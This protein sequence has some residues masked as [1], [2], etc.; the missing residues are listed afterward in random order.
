[1]VDGSG[2]EPW[3]AP[4]LVISVGALL[5]PWLKDRMAGGRVV[6]A[7][8]IDGPAEDEID[9]DFDPIEPIP[10]EFVSPV[11]HLRVEPDPEL[12]KSA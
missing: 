7:V 6:A 5:W 1:M 2:V 3:A 11:G 9:S 12:V 4:L 10:V 8:T